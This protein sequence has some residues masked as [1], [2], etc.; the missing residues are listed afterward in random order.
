MNLQDCIHSALTDIV[1][2]VKRARKESDEH[3]AIIGS[4]PVFGRSV[5]P[6]WKVKFDIAL[7][8]GDAKDTKGRSTTKPAE[9]C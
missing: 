1:A 2:G 8:E 4:D 3:G 5:A 7:T 9:S 6:I